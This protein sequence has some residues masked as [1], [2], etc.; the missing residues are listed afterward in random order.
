M[1]V[2]IV[3]TCSFVGVPHYSCSHKLQCILSMEDGDLDV[4]T[5]RRIVS[6]TV[7]LPKECSELLG[8]SSQFFLQRQAI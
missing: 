8:N 2:I 5:L 4:V 7:F 3:L 1:L 6:A